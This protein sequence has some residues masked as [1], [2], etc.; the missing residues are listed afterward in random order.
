MAAKGHTTSQYIYI[1]A[2][3]NHTL[4]DRPALIALKLVE[5]VDAVMETEEDFR[6]DYPDVFQ[7]LGKLKEP[8]HIV[9]D[10]GATLVALSAPRR[11]RLPLKEAVQEELTR[12][13]DMQGFLRSSSQQNGVLV[14][15]LSRNQERNHR[16]SVWTSLP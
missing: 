10:Q 15:P 4:L 13:E 6:A 5:R 8:Y 16:G 14:W 9:L 1:V 7:G 2:G 3:L 12:M 11:V